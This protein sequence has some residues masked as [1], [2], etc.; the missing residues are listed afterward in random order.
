MENNKKDME[1]IKKVI[2]EELKIIR[3]NAYE[4]QGT[5]NKKYILNRT[6]EILFFIK[7]I[8]QELNK[9]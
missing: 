4:I 5:K 6:D 8:E 2:Y 7:S 9:I 1:A 3:T